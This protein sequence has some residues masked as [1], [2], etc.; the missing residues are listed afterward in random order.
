MATERTAR[1]LAATGLAVIAALLA[2][3]SVV[4]RAQA[5][6]PTST[7]T[8]TAS[9][10]PVAEPWWVPVAFQGHAVT[11][12]RADSGQITA[13]VDGVGQQRSS[14]GGH[15]WQA[16]ADPQ[17]TQ[18]A[19][20]GAWQV[21]DGRAGEL[22]ATGTWHLD[23]GSPHVAQSTTAGRGTVAALPG[24]TGLVVAV[25]VDG[26]VWRRGGDGHW[27]RA[28]LLLNQDA[29][30]GRPQVTG[31]ASFTQPLTAAVYLATDGYSV[32]ES[33]N[34][35]DDWVRGGPGLPDG[36]LAITTDSPNHA[37]YAATRDGLWL[38][39]LQATP[40]PPVYQGEDLRLRIFGVAAVSA[41]AVLLGLG[42][43][44]RLL[45]PA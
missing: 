35:G 13:A 41:V 38:H 33:T 25:D 10:Q 44:L 2:S 22:D 18:P 7:P 32:L 21:R 28:L 19:A 1:R 9:P 16:S 45:R 12:V 24:Y 8:A 30:H 4:A 17:G 31:I 3:P 42:G 6:T 43:M 27:A 11:A 15:T 20:P 5:S 34:G 29:V 23:P 37:V 40:A 14:D 39:H 26:V 36:V